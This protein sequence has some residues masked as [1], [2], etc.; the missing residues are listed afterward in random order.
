[1]NEIKSLCLK[2]EPVGSRVT[3]NPPPLD[4]DIDYLLLV[5]P[6]KFNDFEMVLFDSGYE[7][8]GSRIHAGGC[9][10]GDENSFQSYTKGEVN[11]IV[12]ASE[13]FFIKFMAATAKAKELNLLHKEDRI[14]L[15]QEILY[16][17]NV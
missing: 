11:L 17:V 8:G 6:E 16:G 13:E 3:C 7:M 4:T 12:T 5:E 1:M 15:F 9:L 2:F 10:L 14:A